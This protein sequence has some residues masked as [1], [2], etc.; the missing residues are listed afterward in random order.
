ME[1]GGGGRGVTIGKV[2]PFNI[3]RDLDVAQGESVEVSRGVGTCE[4]LRNFCC[5]WCG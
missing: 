1:G 3:S 2:L 5:K 4:K